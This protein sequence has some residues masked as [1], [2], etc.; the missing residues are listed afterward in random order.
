MADLTVANSTYSTG[1]N[2]TASTLTNNVS[3]TDA[4]Q[5]NGLSTAIIGIQTILGIGTTLKGSLADLVARLAVQIGAD[6]IINPIGSIKMYGGSAAPTGYLLCDGSAVSRTTYASLFTVIS[7]TF[8]VGDGSTTFNVPDMRGR[9]PIGVGTGVGGGSSGTGA[10]TG[11]SA[12]TAVARASWKGTE[13]AVNISHTHTDSG[14]SH[15]ERYDGSLD[16]GGGNNVMSG[17]NNQ[18]TVVD[19]TT[20]GNTTATSSANISTEGVSGTGLNFQ[21]VMGVNFII[22]T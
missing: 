15:V 20:S 9:V 13:N 21:P 3:A 18:D 11:G 22:R 14:H 10:P 7:T 5:Y 4:Q 1:T 16:S 6:G 2:D 12:L 17:A 19:N 8:G